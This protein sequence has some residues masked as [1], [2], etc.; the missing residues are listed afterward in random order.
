[1]TAQKRI[2]VFIAEDSELL[3][4]LLLAAI[5]EIDG[6]EVTGQALTGSSA[7]RSIAAQRPD[8][9]LLDLNM[10]DGDGFAVLSSLPGGTRQEKP[11]IIVMTF[12]ADHFIRRRCDDLGAHLFFDK[13]GDTQVVIDLLAGLADGTRNLADVKN[14]CAMTNLN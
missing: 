5:E 6:V 8:V 7:V 12:E 1:M 4:A 2:T 3:Q 11:L 9:L 14:C 13:A 10:P